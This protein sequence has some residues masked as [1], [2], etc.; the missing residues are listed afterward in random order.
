MAIESRKQIINSF[1]KK[2]PINIAFNLLKE[3]LNTAIES[4][5]LFLIKQLFHSTLVFL[6]FLFYT[7]QTFNSIS[8]LLQ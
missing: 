7:R 5:I 4:I 1:E 2:K 8:S 6:L 3:R